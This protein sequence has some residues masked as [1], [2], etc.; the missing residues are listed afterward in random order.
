[1]K[2]LAKKTVWLLLAALALGSV[3]R[4]TADEADTSAT[5]TLISTPSDNSAPFAGGLTKIA[6]GE[7]TIFFIVKGKLR[8][9]GSNRA[10]EAGVDVNTSL[11]I[12]AK[13]IKVPPSVKFTDAA[14]AG[15][16][17]CG[18][19]DTGHVWTWG[20]NGHGEFGNGTTDKD[21]VFHLPARIETD[22]DGQP[23]DKVKNVV[24]AFHTYA[25]LK[26][27]GSV[28]VWGFSGNDHAGL[29]CTGMAGDG[30]K[31][32]KDLTRPIHVPFPEG[33]TITQLSA[34]P[35][36]MLALD[37]EGAVWSWGGGADTAPDRGTGVADG[38]VP[39]KLPKLPA[40]KAIAAGGGFNY[41]IDN[42]GNLWG[43]GR[44]GAYMCLGDG[45]NYSVPTPL[46]VKLKFPDLDGRMKAVV[47]SQQTTHVIRDD[48]TVWGWGA[49][50]MGEVGD[51]TCNDWAAMTPATYSWDWGRYEKMVMKP[52]Q[53]LDDVQAVY[54]SPQAPYLFAVKNDGTIWSWGRNKTGVLCNGV[55]PESQDCAAH[56]NKWDVVKP[57]QVKPF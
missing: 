57:A 18:L 4:L 16:Q 48:N 13:S 31:S 20:A 12:P 3:L 45:K 15:Y 38:S 29:D 50:P 22:V 7:Y 53:V 52:V 26:E 24:A 44:E 36:A 2:I 43:W 51:G 8:A 9:M 23:F 32:S 25:A 46:P 40:V 10:Q 39:K 54:G 11:T 41:A 34:G 56:P 47:T 17:S 19:D 6:P 1:M 14:A 37:S 30:D 42:E 27:D 55:Y 35:I 21:N 28:W 33:I 5:N 49:S